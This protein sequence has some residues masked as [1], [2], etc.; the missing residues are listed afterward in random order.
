M[1]GVKQAAIAVLLAVALAGC[2][3]S[4][5]PQ[6]TVGAVRNVQARRFLAGPFTAGTPTR[7]SFRIDQPS[8]EPAHAL[9]HG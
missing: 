8:G 6:I 9:P 2:G 5:S 4:G 3:S 1:P 7:L